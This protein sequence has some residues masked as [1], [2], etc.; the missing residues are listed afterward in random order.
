M[1]FQNPFPL[2]LH[3]TT[4]L[5]PSPT[6]SNMQ[7]LLWSAWTHSLPGRHLLPHLMHHYLTPCSQTHCSSR[8]LLKIP[9]CFW[10]EAFT[11]AGS[12]ACRM[13]SLEPHMAGPRTS[14]RSPNKCSQL[15]EASREHPLWN[16]P[17]SRPRLPDDPPTPH[18]CIDCLLRG[19]SASAPLVLWTGLF[20]AVEWE[21]L[22]HALWDAEQHPRPIFTS[23]QKHP[24]PTVTT[25]NDCRGLPQWASG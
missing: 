18:V 9:P 17:S 22:S 2:V 24:F 8:S 7:L 3:S 13:L 1:V 10:C 19:F 16:T 12:S 14:L 23:C 21:G 25:E 6:C 15:R 11:L 5:R 20:W 4:W